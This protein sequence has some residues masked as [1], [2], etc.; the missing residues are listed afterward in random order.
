M[1]HL[2]TVGTRREEVI[3]ILNH[4]CAVGLRDEFEKDLI[5]FEDRIIA[6]I[7]HF[8]GFP[9]AP[10][11]GRQYG[12]DKSGLASTWRALENEHTLGRFQVLV[13]KPLDTAQNG[14]RLVQQQITG[15]LLSARVL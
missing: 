14:I 6:R 8:G 11:Y 15:S 5:A 4:K 12:S 9:L 10:R 1:Q 2:I 13:D 7:E 3:G